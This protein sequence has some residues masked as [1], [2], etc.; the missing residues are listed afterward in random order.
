[1]MSARQQDWETAMAST[2]RWWRLGLGSWPTV[3]RCSCGRRR[4]K[5]GSAG[6][7]PSP[8]SRRPAMA[9]LLAPIFLL[10]TLPMHYLHKF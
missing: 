10:E 5:V 7:N 6:R 4:A 1:M 2:A 8:A 9:S 3:S